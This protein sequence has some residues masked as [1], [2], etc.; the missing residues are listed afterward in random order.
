MG[1]MQSPVKPLS[2][3]HAA[4][5]GVLPAPHGFT[6]IELMVVIAMIAILAALAAPSFNS[7]ME[8][9]RVFKAVKGMESTLH[10]ARSEAI[11]RNGLVA[12]QKLA[13]STDCSLAKTNQEWSCGW[14]IFVDSDN[15]GSLDNN[16]EVLQITPAPK[17]VNIIMGN[18]A[19]FLRVDRWGQ[20][21]NLGTAG[22]QFSP[23]PTGV[24]SPAT[25]RLCVSSG[26]RIDARRQA[27][28]C[29]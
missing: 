2:S 29:S 20:I 7:I 27:V 8:R 11:K 15:D 5:R 23:H 12:I 17:N 19:R 28:S 1:R 3:A 21:S 16:E 4:R 18:G 9:W 14:Q 6:A 22:I 26:G 24:S 10:L 25:T 13:N